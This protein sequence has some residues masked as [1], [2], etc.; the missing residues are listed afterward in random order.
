MSWQPDGRQAPMH[1]GLSQSQRYAFDTF[2]YL[3]LPGVL[4]EDQVA[5]LRATLA[6]P[7][8]QFDPVAK[9]HNPLHWDAV[10]RELLD[11][12]TLAPVLEALV[13]NHAFR[14]RFHN[15]KGREPHPTYRLDHINVH[16]HVKRGFAGGQLHGGWADSGGSQ[17]FRYEDGEFFNGLVAVSF[18]LYDTH[19]N[20][21]GF[22]CIPGSHRSQVA[23]DDAWRDLSNVSADVAPWLRRI[24]AT[25]GDAIVFTEALT[26]GTLPW[27]VD[28]PRQTVFYKFS[29]HGAA[30]SADFFD[31]DDYRAYADMTARK[32]AV[33]E[34]PNARYPGRPGAPA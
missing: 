28:D 20:D 15:A 33:L 34:P 29:P 5:R 24:A 4:S 18:E 1:D 10:W 23:F 32:L 27:N 17:F 31:P 19:G 14:R 8:E 25:P 9:A 6:Q 13:G 3:V 11:L 7:T 22:V 2:G 26:H 30:W 21:G 12:P 16:T